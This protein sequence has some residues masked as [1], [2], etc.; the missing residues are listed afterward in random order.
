MG[1]ENWIKNLLLLGT[2]VGTGVGLGSY[3]LHKTHEKLI[4]EEIHRGKKFSP[5]D[6][7]DW[8]STLS[9]VVPAGLIFLLL[10]TSSKKN[11]NDN[12]FPEELPGEDSSSEDQKQQNSEIHKESPA[13]IFPPVS[14]PTIVPP[15]HPISKEKFL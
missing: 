9:L 7:I 13:I 4:P 15:L 3:L 12:D 5:L 14:H 1:K 2:G 11:E 6:A 10:S 8:G